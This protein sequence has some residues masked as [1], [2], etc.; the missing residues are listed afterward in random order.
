MPNVFCFILLHAVVANDLHLF[1][2]VFLVDESERFILFH[3]IF[4][5]QN[6]GMG[7][8][9]RYACMRHYMTYIC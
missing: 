5:E 1:I 9:Y 8:I 6:S 4:D 7:A 2:Q 3:L